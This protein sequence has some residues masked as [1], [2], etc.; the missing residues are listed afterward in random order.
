[1]DGYITLNEASQRW[2]ISERRTRFLC[3]EGRVEGAIKFGRVWAIP[4]NASKP[5]DNRITTGNYRKNR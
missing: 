1:M 3:Q 5:A 4:T 2:G